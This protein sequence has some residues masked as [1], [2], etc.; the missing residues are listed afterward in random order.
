MADRVLVTGSASGL[1]RAIAARF[2]RAGARVLV[3]D[4]DIEAAEVAA[5]ELGTHA[6]RLDVTSDD[7]WATA[8]DWCERE[9]GGLD[10]LVNNAGV[11]AGGRFEKIG[12][13]DWNWIWEINVAGV[14][15]GCRTFTPDFKARGSGHLVNVASLAAIMNLPAMSSYNVTKAAVL[16]LSD[17]LRLELAPYGVHTTVVCPGFV[18]TNLEARLR[19]PDPAI[20]KLMHRL[21]LSSKVTA[22]DVAAQV[23]DAVARK[24]FLVL[25]HRDG[26]RSALLKR[27]GLTDR[28]VRR[29]WARLREAVEDK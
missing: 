22:D 5:K 21:M 27:F 28:Q 11:G 24:R 25:T 15:R 26:R 10:V 16:S 18:R 8:R 1:G 23:F 6:V 20:A 29:Y 13:A 3:S 17:T 19:S 4:V 9:W 7:D 2:Q 12:M 14:V